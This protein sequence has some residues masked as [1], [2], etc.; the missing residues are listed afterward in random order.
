MFFIFMKFRYG[1][2][3]EANNKQVNHV[4]YQMVISSEEKDKEG[5]EHRE[6]S[7]RWF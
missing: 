3:E 2:G 4:V 1:V 5:E 6:A 7:L